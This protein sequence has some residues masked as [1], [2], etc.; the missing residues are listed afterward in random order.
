MT[1]IVDVLVGHRA[2]PHVY[3]FDRGVEAAKVLKEMLNGM[4]PEKYTIRLP[5][6]AQSVTQ[7]AAEGFPYG[8]LIRYGQK[9]LDKDIFNVTILSGF[10]FGDTPKNGMNIIVHSR[11]STENERVL[12]EKLA[13][14]VWTDRTLYVPKITSLEHAVGLALQGQQSVEDVLLLFADP[15]DK[16]GG[17]GRRNTTYILEA[18]IAAGIEKCVFSVFYDAAAVELACKSRVNSEIEI[19]LNCHETNEYSK[20]LKVKTRAVYHSTQ[21]SLKVTMVWLQVLQLIPKKQLCLT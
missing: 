10:A 19:T 18:F 9:F 11:S 13:V 12:G 21:V 20:Q 5:R 4:K 14:S 7:L 2:N 15:A 8:N 3:M 6:V 16:P 1:S 17:G